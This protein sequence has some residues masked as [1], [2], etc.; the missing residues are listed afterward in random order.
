MTPLQPRPDLEVPAIVRKVRRPRTPPLRRAMF[1]RALG[2]VAVSAG[3]GAATIISAPRAI[4]APLISMRLAEP[5]AAFPAR[6]F[7]ASLQR[8]R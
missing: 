1:I 4:H 8:P 7:E 2:L 3:I 5:Q 6:I